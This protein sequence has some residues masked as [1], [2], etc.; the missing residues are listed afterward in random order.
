MV[1]RY[2]PYVD[3]VQWTGTNV[4]EIRQFVRSEGINDA[5]IR[6]GVL[7]LQ[8]PF[9]T[10]PPIPGIGPVEVPTGNWIVNNAGV[11][12]TYTQEQFDG[13]YELDI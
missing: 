10:N 6:D 9:P 4:T 5:V 13:K 3:A 1:T 12:E 7:Y 2:R 11:I 8:P